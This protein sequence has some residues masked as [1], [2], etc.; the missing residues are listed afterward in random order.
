MKQKQKQQCFIGG[1]IRQIAPNLQFEVLKTPTAPLWISAGRQGDRVLKQ[2]FY[3]EIAAGQRARLPNG[4]FNHVSARVGLFGSQALFGPHRQTL[5]SVRVYA[6][7]LLHSLTHTHT[8][9][10][11]KAISDKLELHF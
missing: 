5:Y 10:H 8:Q 1:S 11:T 2:N 7:V 9:A 6:C 4:H 3:I